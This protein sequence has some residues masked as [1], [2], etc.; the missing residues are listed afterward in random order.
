MLQNRLKS[1]WE[2]A[3]TEYKHT[4]Y[5]HTANLPYTASQRSSVYTWLLENLGLPGE[6]YY[7]THGVRELAV[8]FT[9]EQNYI[10]FT[11]RWS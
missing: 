4:E 9:T 1:Y 6:Q 10:W 7:V 8:H 5:K 3:D 11:L 2:Q